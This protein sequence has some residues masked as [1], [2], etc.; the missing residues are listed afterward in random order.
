MCFGLVVVIAAGRINEYSVQIANPYFLVA[1]A[2]DD[3]NYTDV[4]MGAMA[5]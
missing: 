4:I 3:S 1:G 2:C 5:S